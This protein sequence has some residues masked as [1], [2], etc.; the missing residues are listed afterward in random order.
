MTS[1]F[2]PLTVGALTLPN[3]IIMAPMTRSRADDLGRVSELTATYYAQRASAGLI[4]TEGI[5]PSAM[6]KG[7]IRTPGLATAE[8][9]ARWRTVT[10][11]VHARGGRI[12]AQL[13]H[14]GRVSDPSFLPDGALPVAPSAIAARGSSYTPEGPKPL[15][16][17]RELRT[18]EI[19]PIVDEFRLGAARAFDAGFDAVEVHA[20]SGYLLE[21]FL[22]TGTN[23]RTD[24]YGGSLEN[25]ARFALEVV[26]A[27]SQ[28]RGADRVGVKIA[29]EL[30]FNDVHDA[31]PTETYA[32][33]TDGLS[34]EG[35]AYLHVVGAPYH[36]LLRPRFGGRYFAGGGFDGTTA[37]A[38]LADGGADAVV[39]GA[40]FIAN[41][42]LPAR[43][44][45]RRPLAVPE[46]ETFYSE[47]PRGYIDYP[48]AG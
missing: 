42:D 5:F 18:S 8:H 36:A 35:I 14:T 1:L 12:V 41:P 6:G 33:L 38:L 19:A 13:M 32:Y 37:T 47:G 24:A 31:S 28:V 26:R 10:A 9:V 34:Q 39:F 21:Q 25:R 11:A 45:D 7:Y 2:D 3:R 23:Q 17:P 27:V 15:P 43:L 16:V 48:A 20:A 30:G 22:S 44:R 4:I 29:P 40:P 46:R